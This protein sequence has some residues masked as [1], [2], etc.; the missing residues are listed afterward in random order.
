MRIL[1][2]ISGAAMAEDWNLNLIVRF[3]YKAKQSS[4]FLHI[5]ISRLHVGSEGGWFLIFHLIQMFWFMK[6]FKHAKFIGN[7]RNRRLI[8]RLKRIIDQ[9]K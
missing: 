5:V 7:S 1:K 9:M 8:Y 6:Y 2:E 4:R 3:I